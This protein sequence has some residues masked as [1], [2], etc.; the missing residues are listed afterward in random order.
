MK[1]KTISRAA[2]ALLASGVALSAEAAAKK[3][4]E[5]QPAAVQPAAPEKKP[6]WLGRMLGKKATPEKKVELPAVA[7]AQKASQPKAEAPAKPTQPSKPD[8]AK[9]AANDKKSGSWL[10]WMLG[11]KEEKPTKEEKSEANVVK[12]TQTAL[13]QEKLAQSK[14]ADP[15]KPTPVPVEPAKKPG[16][17][18]RIF[19]GWGGDANSSA[20]DGSKPLRPLDWAEK[21]IIK[22]EDVAAYTYGPSQATG[23][24]DRLAKGTLV[25]LKRA[26]KSWSEVE[27]ENGR[28]Y[29]VGSDQIRKAA[30]DDFADPVVQTAQVGGG[31]AEYYEPLPPPN[32]PEA[33][34]ALEPGAPQI[35]LPPLPE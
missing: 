20:V 32:L 31:S 35:L 33:G 18:A 17:L 22:D 29:T 4:P 10:G 14:K 25:T 3:Q 28:R 13:A 23:P 27:L 34:G 16:F 1:K 11:K 2:A 19:G 8:E 12:K 7:A 9:P 30:F 5:S 15:A 6:S 21:H 26:G 24:D